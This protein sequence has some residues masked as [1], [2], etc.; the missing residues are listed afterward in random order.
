MYTFQLLL[1][2][3]TVEQKKISVKGKM[4]SKCFMGVDVEGITS[5]ACHINVLTFFLQRR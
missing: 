5:F 4:K 3:I 1:L 2:D